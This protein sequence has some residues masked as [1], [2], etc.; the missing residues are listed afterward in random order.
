MASRAVDLEVMVQA[1]WN[2]GTQIAFGPDPEFSREDLR[3]LLGVYSDELQQLDDPRGELIALDLLRTPTTDDARRLDELRADFLG[4]ALAKHPNVNT[5]YGLVGVSITDLDSQ[6][7][8]EVLVSPGA[9]FVSSV[10]IFGGELTVRRTLAMLASELRPWLGALR[11]VVPIPPAGVNFEDATVPPELAVE[12]VAATPA[13]YSLSLAGAFVVR[14]L[15]HPS[16]RRLV[17]SGYEACGS[18]SG[19]GAPLENIVEL[20]F[21]FQTS[22]EPA[23]PT[24]RDLV[25]LLST[26]YLPALRR[27][28]LSRNEPGYHAPANLGGTVSIY[29]FLR[30]LA[31][32]K[33]LTHARLPAVRSEQDRDLLQAVLDRMDALERLEVTRLH[34][35][36]H[37]GL[38]HPTATLVVPT[39]APWPRELDDHGVLLELTDA[40]ELELDLRALVATME[41][42][43]DS[44]PSDG[45]AMW[46]QWWEAIAGASTFDF[47]AAWLLAA[48]EA[49]GTI[50]DDARWRA[51]LEQLRR[52]HDDT[53]RVT[54]I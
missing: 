50:L 40:V 1:A 5:R 17:V 52:A 41:R 9:P 47:P 25:A 15:A 30:S 13:L 34:G 21:A 22:G 42:G 31:V 37:H 51:V 43:Y 33:Q 48:L 23:D 19:V 6:L 46:D 24:P 28:D 18:L 49:C 16:L 45:R 14:E 38:R 53:V 32:A 10:S 3:A 8:A 44:L 54:R 35:R 36:A 7:L 2:R 4:K 12:L 29:R 20:D 26:S 39:S 27:L 11:I